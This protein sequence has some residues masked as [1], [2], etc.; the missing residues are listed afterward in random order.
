MAQKQD[1]ALSAM[2]EAFGVA[3]V[4]QHRHSLCQGAPVLPRM[5]RMPAPPHVPVRAASPA[6]GRG[7]AISFKGQQLALQ[8]D[9]R[10]SV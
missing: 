1:F 6:R 5:R 2:L 4:S 3:G 10:A 7:A 9:V 8:P